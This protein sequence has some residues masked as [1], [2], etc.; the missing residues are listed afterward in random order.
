MIDAD[1]RKAIHLLKS[2]GMSLGAISRQL[3]VSIG[4]VRAIVKSGG[5]PKVIARNDRKCVSEELLRRLFSECQGYVQRVHERL[6]DE[7]KIEIGYST[8][9]RLCRSQGLVESEH[10][11]RDAQVP[12]EPGIEMQHDTS[13]YKLLL[14]GQ[15]TNIVGSSLY[16]RYCKRRFVKFYPSFNRFRMKCF[17]HEALDHFGYSARDCIIDNTNLAVLRGSGKRAVMVPEMIRF[18]EQ[19]GFKW[20]AHEIKHSDRKGGIE[21]GFWFIETNFFPGR[22]FSTFEDL[23][24]QAFDWATKRISLRPHKKT[25]LIPAE[26]F[27]IEKPFLKKIPA[28]VS[29]PVIEHDRGTD[30]YGYAS[31]DGNFF[32]VP[33]EGR[34][35]V[36]VLEFA[37]KIRIVQNRK[38]L[39]EYARPPW[40][41]KGKPFKPDN[42]PAIRPRN[43]KRPTV[44]EER[45]LLAMGPESAS[46]LEVVKKMPLSIVKRN[47]FIRQL[48]RLS[49]KLAPEVF[50]K[51]INRALQYGVTD[52]ETLERMAVYLL[53]DGPYDS[54]DFE[55]ESTSV[56]DAHPELDVSEP[57]DFSHYDER[58]E[59]EDENGQGSGE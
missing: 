25:R 51:V 10:Q 27:E 36:K 20:F 8:L 42:V 47:Q 7:N 16:L 14:N 28:Y 21:S 30:Q 29:P 1:K 31:C 17:F 23:N 55:L 46:Y 11:R 32:W 9:T 45:R 3:R 59:N 15:S 53:R 2:E 39:I 38:T 34:G 12:D 48:H 40:G 13:P 33:G 41:V 19:Y 57:P 4:T 22:T 49:Q 54:V 5:M 26:L 52:M 18:A 43:Q 56:V 35:E 6:K 50:I 24:Q 58:V 37:G 44:A